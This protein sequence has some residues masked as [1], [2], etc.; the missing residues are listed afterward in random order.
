MVTT[1]IADL[2]GWFASASLAFAAAQSIG[3][4]PARVNS[5]Q[6]GR[7]W[8]FAGVAGTVKMFPDAEDPECVKSYP[9]LAKL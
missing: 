6:S 3:R 2:A 1:V 4:D 5:L 9:P 8:P 7:A